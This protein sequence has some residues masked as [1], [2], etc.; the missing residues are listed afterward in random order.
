MEKAARAGAE[1]FI[2][3]LGKSYL[4]YEVKPAV[5]ELDKNGYCDASRMLAAV[6]RTA[7]HVGTAPIHLGVLTTSEVD[8]L[9]MLAGGMV[10]KEVALDSGRSLSTVRAHIASAV[11]K[12]QCNRQADAI[13][14]ARKRGLL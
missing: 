1:K 5:E 14:E 8:I 4:E 13:N 10:A 11:R 9:R 3:A 12:L 2:E 7:E 6:C